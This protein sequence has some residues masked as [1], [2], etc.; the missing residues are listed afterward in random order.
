[1]PL[2]LHVSSNC[3]ESYSNVSIYHRPICVDLEDLVRF[4]MVC[5]ANIT[6]AELTLSLPKDPC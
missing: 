1:M 3:R 2:F 6:S 4:C 5:S